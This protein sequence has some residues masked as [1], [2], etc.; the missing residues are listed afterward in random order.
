M[1]ISDYREASRTEVLN[2]SMVDLGRFMHGQTIFNFPRKH[3]IRT[4]SLATIE[5]HPGEC[6]EFHASGWERRGLYSMERRQAP[7]PS[8]QVLDLSGFFI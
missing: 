6:K 2:I 4:F 7:L 5:L 3:E 1:M 8:M